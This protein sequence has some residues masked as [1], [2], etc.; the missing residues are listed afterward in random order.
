MRV[1]SP[2]LRK[3]SNDWRLCCHPVGGI[4]PRWRVCELTDGFALY[5]GIIDKA[6]GVQLSNSKLDI[7]QNHA[8]F[9]SWRCAGS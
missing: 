2:L 9:S 7:S 5:L 6:A 1:R 4:E 3:L 8:E